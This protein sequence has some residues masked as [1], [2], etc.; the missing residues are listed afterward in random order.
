MSKL[1]TTTGK[2]KVDLTDPEITGGSFEPVPDD[3]YSVTVTGH[4]VRGPGESGYEYIN[5]AF[6]VDEGEFKGRMFWRNLSLSPKALGFL[7]ELCDAAGISYDKNGVDLK[8]AK[9]KRLKVRIVTETSEEYGDQNRISRFLRRTA[10]SSPSTKKAF[11][12]TDPK[13][14]KAKSL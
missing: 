9:G 2:A 7:K 5:F 1:I 11:K 6:T 3:D 8:S 14:K 12:K 4:E 10:K 13:K